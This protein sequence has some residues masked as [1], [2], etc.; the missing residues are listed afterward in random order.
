MPSASRSVASRDFAASCA[1]VS[2]V[3]AGAHVR[4]GRSAVDIEHACEHGDSAQQC[5]F[6]RRKQTVAPVERRRQSA[7][8]LRA[9]PAP[10]KEAESIV[11]LLQQTADTERI[12]ARRGEFDRKRETIES[13]ADLGDRRRVGVAQLEQLE[14]VGR[15]VY[16]ELNGRERQRFCGVQVETRAAARPA[17]AACGRV[18]LSLEAALGW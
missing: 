6:A 9:R 10:D 3:S 13:A 7:V 18:L 17:P 8:S 4:N 15:A 11:E 12:D 1:R 2:A 5:G 16:K 14:A